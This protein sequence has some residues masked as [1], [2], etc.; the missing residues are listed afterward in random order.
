MDKMKQK[1]P[2]V[3]KDL[4]YTVGRGMDW[5]SHFGKLFPV[6]AKAEYMNAL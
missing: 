2:D 6:S 1:M 3:Y 5:Y 4:S